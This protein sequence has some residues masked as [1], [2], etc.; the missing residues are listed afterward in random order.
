MH[1]RTRFFLTPWPVLLVA[2]TTLAL[3][4]LLIPTIAYADDSQQG[5]EQP[6]IEFVDGYQPHMDVEN[7]DLLFFNPE[8]PKK[9]QTDWKNKR[10][11]LVESDL[12]EKAHKIYEALK[13]K[14]EQ[15]KNNADVTS[16]LKEKIDAGKVSIELPGVGKGNVTF[17]D[18]TPVY[19]VIPY[20]EISGASATRRQN[21]ANLNQLS[22]GYWYRTDLS[23]SRTLVI[24]DPRVGR[25][26]KWFEIDDP[27]IKAP[28]KIVV[29]NV[30]G[31]EPLQLRRQRFITHQDNPADQADVGLPVYSLPEGVTH[32]DGHFYRDSQSSYLYLDKQ[33][34]RHFSPDELKEYLFQ[35]LSDAGPEAFRKELEE[36]PP[37]RYSDHF[38]QF[39]SRQFIDSGIDQRFFKSGRDVVFVWGDDTPSGK[40]FRDTTDYE[41]ILRPK[42]LGFTWIKQWMNAKLAKPTL[43]NLKL[44]AICTTAQ[45]CISSALAYGN[46]ML[47]PDK[48]FQPE[49]IYLSAIYGA[50]VGLFVR[51]YL[52]VMKQGTQLAQW[53][54]QVL[55]S[56]SF[57][58]GLTLWTEGTF[59]AFLPMD[60]NGA[61][62]FAAL[63]TNFWLWMNIFINSKTK[64]EMDQWANILRDKRI[65][66]VPWKFGIKKS[67][68]HSQ[69]VNAN[70]MFT[71]KMADLTGF[72]VMGVP[73]GKLLFYLMGPVIQ[74]GTVIWARKNGFHEE[75]DKLQK[76][77]E[78][79]KG[80]VFAPIRWAGQLGYGV[81]MLTKNA[82]KKRQCA[83]ALLPPQ[84]LEQE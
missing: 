48:A 32:H 14:F 57:T 81:F 51:T 71:A 9:I 68:M 84:P 56:M 52:N 70:V 7:H 18:K 53:V 38:W 2:L 34:F 62:N 76:R 60:K 47:N 49:A 25:Y 37:N 12:K 74:K 5:D 72:S 24:D 21:A 69:I 6:A 67:E 10:H 35:R 80:V 43:G 11:E 46:H 27:T 50:T 4:S 30:A 28:R 29:Q 82:M 55:F 77:W 36:F 23:N 39:V 26:K 65:S 19:R 15:L 41:V 31:Q 54:K 73:I 16:E 44:M 33:S 63:V 3:R 83:S 22:G 40:G 61:F 78:H 17:I 13:E 1:K 20:Q 66:T 45:V 75:A 79:A 64:V 58:Y 8:D 59:M 42:K